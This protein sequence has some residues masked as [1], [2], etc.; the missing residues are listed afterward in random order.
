MDHR[1]VG[2]TVAATSLKSWRGALT[3]TVVRRWRASRKGLKPWH[4]HSAMNSL[5]DH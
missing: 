1:T 3:M 2:K 4:R 5:T